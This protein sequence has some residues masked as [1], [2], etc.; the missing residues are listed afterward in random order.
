MSFKT[1]VLDPNIL[2]KKNY[3]YLSDWVKREAFNSSKNK[4]EVS[5]S[6][7]NTIK[8]RIKAEKYIVSKKKKIFDELYKSINKILGINKN[9]RFWKIIIGDW[10]HY[11]FYFSY[12]R[13]FSLKNVLYKYKIKKIIL[14][15]SSYDCVNSNLEF[16]KI[17]NNVEFNNGFFLSVIKNLRFANNKNYKVVI[18]KR[19]ILRNNVISF[20]IKNFVRDFIIRINLFFCKNNSIL[21]V[22]TKLGKLR[23]IYIQ[24]KLKQFP[25]Y[26]LLT[27]KSYVEKKDNQKRKKLFQ[28]F[29]KNNSS[30]N[31]L[32]FLREMIVCYLP[33]NYLEGY[34]KIFTLANRIYPENTKTIITSQNFSTDEVFKYW[35]ANKTESGS[36]YFIMQHGNNYGYYRFPKKYNEELI[37]D[38]FLTWGWSNNKSKYIKFFNFK[39][40]GK[41]KLNFKKNKL[42]FIQ[43]HPPVKLS[44]WDQEK[45]YFETINLNNHF[46]SQLDSSIKKNLIIRMHKQSFD[47]TYYNSMNVTEHQKEY[48]KYFDYGRKDIFS[49]IKKSKIIIYSYDSTGFYENLTLN[50]PVFLLDRF[51]KKNINLRHKKFLQSLEN[52][53]IFDDPA[54]LAMK[55]NTVWAD[56]DKWWYNVVLQKKIRFFLQSYSLYEPN[57]VQK[58]CKFLKINN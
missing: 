47:D 58:M 41:K 56:I 12:N 34:K 6:F 10:F 30:D 25:L 28:L 15:R 8:D 18:R 45:E 17:S 44:F 16:I 29:Y 55:V 49:L 5:N 4:V 38:K 33:T 27:E 53:I 51:F 35:T 14:A 7:C 52:E 26:G 40:S 46:F 39:V 19:N 20:S 13:Y 37:S 21:L 31:F 2:S 42:L 22:D 32:N 36:K 57:P 43:V 54:R 3:I 23:E 11:F 24:L 1:L 9:R 50:N 48:E